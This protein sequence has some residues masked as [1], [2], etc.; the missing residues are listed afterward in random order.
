[1]TKDLQDTTAS[2]SPVTAETLKA[3]L[4]AIEERIL[5]GVSRAECTELRDQMDYS[6]LR[7]ELLA[8]EQVELDEDIRQLI[9]EKRFELYD[10]EDPAK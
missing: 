7:L 9:M 8:L 6:A 3:R 4:A 1:M 2:K 10:G 5:T